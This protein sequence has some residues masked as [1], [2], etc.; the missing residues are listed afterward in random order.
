[1]TRKTKTDS[2]YRPASE[3]NSKAK[4]GRNSVVKTGFELAVTDP[5]LSLKYRLTALDSLARLNPTRR[6]LADL[7]RKTETPSRLRLAA[8]QLLDEIRTA[9]KAKRNPGLSQAEKTARV[10]LER[11]RGQRAAVGGLDEPDSVFGGLDEK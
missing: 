3:P 6:F 11:L 9:D 10:L 5:G 2:F 8:T 4:R 1:M 7:I